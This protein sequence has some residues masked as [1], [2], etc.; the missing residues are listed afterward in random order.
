V[1]L[2]TGVSR[3]GIGCYLSTGCAQVNH[4]LLTHSLYKLLKNKRIFYIKC[5]S[6]LGLGASMEVVFTAEI[7]GQ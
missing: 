2:S 7:T 3:P 4:C 1:L 5:K 6:V